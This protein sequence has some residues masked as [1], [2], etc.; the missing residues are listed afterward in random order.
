MLQCSHLC[1]WEGKDG[2]KSIYHLC[3]E[4]K[5]LILRVYFNLFCSQKIFLLLHLILLCYCLLSIFANQLW[6]WARYDVYMWTVLPFSWIKG[7]KVEKKSVKMWGTKFSPLGVFWGM[8]CSAKVQS[9]TNSSVVHATSELVKLQ[10][11]TNDCAVFIAESPDQI[12]SP[13]QCP[14]A[15]RWSHCRRGALYFSA[16]SHLREQVKYSC[17]T[18]SVNNHEKESKLHGIAQLSS[19]CGASVDGLTWV[20]GNWSNVHSVKRVFYQKQEML[21]FFS[22]ILYECVTQEKPEMLP[23]YIAIDQ[24]K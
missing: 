16:Q 7:G 22:S 18:P 10:K 15:F 2:Y 20:E 5:K 1:T 17:V 14:A 21:D 12:L 23:T 4:T 6:T 3:D 11:Y 13:V 9:S 8:L 24:V 19:I